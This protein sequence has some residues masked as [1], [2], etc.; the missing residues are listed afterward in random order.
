MISKKISFTDY[1]FQNNHCNRINKT[2]MIFFHK[3]KKKKILKQRKIK[4]TFISSIF[5]SDKSVRKR[6]FLH[7]KEQILAQDQPR[8]ILY[9]TI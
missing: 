5:K 8:Q 9:C 1:D 6:Y 3:K 7:K 4:Q 2:A